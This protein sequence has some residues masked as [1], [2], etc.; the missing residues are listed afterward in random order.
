MLTNQTA[1]V[2]TRHDYL[3][4]GDEIPAGSAGRNSQ[5]GPYVDNVNQKFTGEYRDTET[6][7]DFFGAR[8]YS[9]PLMRFLTPDPAGLAA[10]DMTDPQTWNQYT[11]VRNNPL[12]LVDPSGMWAMAP[13]GIDGGPCWTDPFDDSFDSS[14]D[15]GGLGPCNLPIPVL[16]PVFGGGGGGGRG[17]G[18]GGTTS[19]TAPEPPPMPPASGSIPTGSFP[20]GENLG[21]PPGL[22]VPGPLSWQALLGLWGWE[23]AGGICVP[24]AAPM[25]ADSVFS[26]YDNESETRSYLAYAACYLAA[27]PKALFTAATGIGGTVALGKGYQLLFAPPADLVRQV[28]VRVATTGLKWGTKGTLIGAAIFLATF[29]VETYNAAKSCSD[30]TGY[31]PWALQH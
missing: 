29:E 27:Q 11:Y 7:N 25:E 24:G 2:I 22:T 3:P 1:T 20:G 23:C 6:L 4:F 13:V 18:G 8:Y 14:D 28:P 15:P 16:P 9:A 30:A 19:S 5:F 17:A 26:G 31:V 21:L 10:V 12:A